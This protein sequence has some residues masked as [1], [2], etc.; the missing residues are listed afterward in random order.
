MAKEEWGG[1]VKLFTNLQLQSAAFVVIC[2]WPR[3]NGVEL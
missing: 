1:I 2:E 3:K